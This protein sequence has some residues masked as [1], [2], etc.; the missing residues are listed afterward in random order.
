MSERVCEQEYNQYNLQ[1]H[2]H[3]ITTEVVSS[4]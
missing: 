1:Q 2:N 3:E 4:G